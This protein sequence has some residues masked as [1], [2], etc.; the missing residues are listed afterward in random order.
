[1]RIMEPRMKRWRLPQTRAKA[2]KKK[3]AV[4]APNK[5]YPV[6]RATWVNVRWRTEEYQ[7]ERV[8]VFAAIMGPRA[9]AKTETME[10]IIRMRSLF[11]RGQ[12]RREC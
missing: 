5:K 7:R 2:T 10:R 6:R 12:F 3:A 8:R 1:M 4:P 9:W 11:Q